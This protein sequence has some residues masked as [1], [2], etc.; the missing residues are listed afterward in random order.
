VARHV[1][2]P[3]NREIHQIGAGRAEGEQVFLDQSRPKLPAN[4]LTCLVLLVNVRPAQQRAVRPQ[5]PFGNGPWWLMP[6]RIAGARLIRWV[7]RRHPAELYSLIPSRSIPATGWRGCPLG[8]GC[9]LQRRSR[10]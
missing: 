1:E 6:R 7:A 9:P 8:A 3:R 4:V 2:D 5:L 10:W